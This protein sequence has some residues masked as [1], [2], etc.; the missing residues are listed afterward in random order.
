MRLDNETRRRILETVI[1]TT[2]ADEEFL[3][4]TQRVESPEEFK[5][6]ALKLYTGPT[7]EEQ[8]ARKQYFTYPPGG[9]YARVCRTVAMILQAL[10]DPEDRAAV[11]RQNALAEI[12]RQAPR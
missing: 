10:E 8:S 12:M 9:F 4:H 7:W 5:A 2:L 3:L 6:R 1:L 11:D